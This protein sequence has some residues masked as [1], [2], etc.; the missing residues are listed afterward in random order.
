MIAQQNFK[1]EPI[2]FV[3]LDPETNGTAQNS[4]K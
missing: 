1:E 4:W 3:Q 2:P